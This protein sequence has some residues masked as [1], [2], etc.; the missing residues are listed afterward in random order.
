MLV[1]ESYSDCVV[2]H[3][4]C[5][6]VSVNVGGVLVVVIVIVVVVVVVMVDWVRSLMTYQVPWLC[7][8]EVAS[9]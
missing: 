1:V 5:R 6:L 2:S 8:S 7:P 9:E 4:V 3:V